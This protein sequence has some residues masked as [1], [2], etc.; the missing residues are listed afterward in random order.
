MG[1]FNA[2]KAIGNGQLGPGVFRSFVIVA[3]NKLGEAVVK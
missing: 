2:R 1:E 3:P